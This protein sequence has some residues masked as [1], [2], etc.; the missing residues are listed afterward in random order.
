MLGASPLLERVEVR[1][2]RNRMTSL[3]EEAASG[4][5]RRDRLQK[6]LL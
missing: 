3:A 5:V 1:E 6:E 4:P 2:N